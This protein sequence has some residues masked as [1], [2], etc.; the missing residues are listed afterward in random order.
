MFVFVLRVW[1][2]RFLVLVVDVARAESAAKE[3]QMA[4]ERAT[5]GS[6]LTAAEEDRERLAKRENFD[7]VFEKARSQFSK[8]EA[9]VYRQGD[10]MIIRLKSMNFS[11]G[12]AELPSASMIILNKVKDVIGD[13]KT[14]DITIEGHTDSTGSASANKKLST[15]RASAV[16]DYFVAENSMPSNKVESIGYGYEKP[17][18]TNK[19]KAGRQMNRR[20]DIVIKPTSSAQNET[21]TTNQ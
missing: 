16:A 7:K 13:L 4:S 2:R 6:K 11:T 5:M 3:K 8:E 10:N 18:A 12:R 17:I 14:E 21:T 20:V 9:D 19:S 1:L 15:D